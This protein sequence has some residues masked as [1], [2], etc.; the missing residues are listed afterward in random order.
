[1][2]D[3]IFQIRKELR[4]LQCVAAFV[5]ICDAEGIA[6]PATVYKALDPDRFNVN[7]VQHRLIVRRAITFLHSQNTFLE[8]NVDDV[9]PESLPAA[10][11]AA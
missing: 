9:C 6:S 11:V 3:Y 4:G 1:M 5:S 7:R 2:E 8:V 10:A